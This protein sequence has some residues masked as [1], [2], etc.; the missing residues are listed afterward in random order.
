MGI[1]LV[2]YHSLRSMV[3][4]YLQTNDPPGLDLPKV[5]R[6]NRN[7]A[8]EDDIEELGEEPHIGLHPKSVVRTSHSLT[9]FYRYDN[10]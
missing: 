1:F 9:G 5:A 10:K 4:K 3:L 7:T 6:P 2:R 8:D